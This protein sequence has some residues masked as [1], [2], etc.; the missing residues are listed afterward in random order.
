MIN[1]LFKNYSDPTTDLKPARKDRQMGG[2]RRITF[3]PMQWK[4]GVGTLPS[5]AQYLRTKRGNLIRIGPGGRKK[6]K[7]PK[8][9][10][11]EGA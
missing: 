10:Q 6:S 5:G 11:K 4:K 1:L 3:Y 8:Q 9:Q 2:F 7:Q